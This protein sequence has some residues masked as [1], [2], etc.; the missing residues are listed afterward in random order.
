MAE[1]NIAQTAASVLQ[2]QFYHE[3]LDYLPREPADDLAHIC[4]AWQRATNAAWVWLWLHNP[5]S[6]TFELSACAGGEEKDG[7]CA[8]ILPSEREAPGRASIGAYCAGKREAIFVDDVHNWRGERDGVT[9]RVAMASALEALGCVGFEC[10]PLLGPDD[11]GG[12]APLQPLGLISVHY[13][14]LEERAIHSRGALGD[15]GRLTALCIRNSKM[16]EQRAILVR[17]NQIVQRYV[18]RPSRRPAEIRAEYLANLIELIQ[19]HIHVAKV[20]IFYEVPHADA[21]ECIATTGLSDASGEPVPPNRLSQAIYR[22]YEGLTGCCYASGETFVLR[23]PTQDRR[24][25]GKFLEQRDIT[26][27][28][29]ADDPAA[30]IPI[31]A[32]RGEDQGRKPRARGVIRCVERRALMWPDELSHFDPTEVETLGFIADQVGPV[33]QTF[34]QR[35]ARERAVSVVKHDLTTPLGMICDVTGSVISAQSSG[36]P[37]GEYDLENIQTCAYLALKLA[38]QLDPLPEEVRNLDPRP[39]MLEGSIV[40]RL[41]KMLRRY[42]R[43]TNR[44]DIRYDGLR[45]IPR[46]NIDREQVERALF[47]LLLNA[48]KYSKPETTIQI[49]GL[50][51]QDGYRVDVIDE[52]MGVPVDDQERIF[53]PG[54][55]TTEAERQAQGLGLGLAIARQIMRAQG[56]DVV[57]TSAKGPTTFSLVFPG[58]L[59]VSE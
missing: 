6:G 47:N 30:L 7:V 2:R 28:E 54:Y 1:Q 55:R 9:H 42:A 49:V 37:M 27:Q 20:S 32:P 58:K 21:V 46:L 59:A 4:Q 17:L 11:V 57:L 45:Q 18:S 40:A 51:A 26:V 14:N 29:G 22:A 41:C 25:T 24:F 15:M 53:Q 50:R 8:P 16:T 3:L 13:R 10:V 43:V 56:G 5:Y 52:G 23:R 44:V 33:L 12:T 31:Q 19:Q 35:I 48:I 36:V 38:E 39:T 34:S